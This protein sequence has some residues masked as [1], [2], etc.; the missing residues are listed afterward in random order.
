MTSNVTRATATAARENTP[1]KV[2]HIVEDLN[3]HAVESWLIR[4]LRHAQ[5]RGRA[6]DWSFYCTSG[7]RGALDT[8]VKALGGSVIQSP[9]Q[10]GRKAK[11]VRALRATLLRGSYDVLHCHHDLV[12]AVYLVSAA[13]LSIRRIVHVHNADEQVL[14]P[15]RFKQVLYREPMR[16][17]CLAMADRIVGNSNHTLDTFLAG[18]DR[19][20][21]RDSV[22]Y[23]G[24]DATPFQTASGDRRK[25]RQEIGFAED[26]RIL[27]FADRIVPEKNPLFAVDVLRDIR[28][29]DPNVAG[30]FIGFGSLTEAV[31]A[32]A[33]EFALGTAFRYIGWRDDVAAVMCCCDW[34]IL[35]RPQW[36]LEGFGIAVV[37]AQLAG[38]RLLLSNGIA[39]DP[40]LPTAQFRRLPLAAGSET[41]A[42]AAM[43]LLRAPAPSRTAAEE[44]L[45]HS[46]FAMDTAAA[47]LIALHQ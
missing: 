13:G 2:L 22:L 30:V 34:F 1:A 45:K 21:A 40:L 15:S 23:Y 14:T 37:E 33:E 4:M 18:R 11:F 26:A 19:R 28:R 8:D 42:S 24:I 7:Q 6:L 12:S 43:E 17:A 16:R 41:W 46:P 10:I 32:R 29:L 44:A 47:N 9:V 3:R 20:V 38:L 27:L 39:D 35:P 25:F 5:A 31:R 36:P